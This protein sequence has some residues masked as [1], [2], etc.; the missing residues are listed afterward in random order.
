MNTVDYIDILQGSADHVDVDRDQLF[1]KDW[2]KFRTFHNKR[3]KRAWNRWFW[4]DISKTEQRFFRADWA[5]GTTYALADEVYYPATDAYYT[6]LRASTAEAPADSSGVTNLD[7]WAASESVLSASAFSATT[8]YVQGNQVTYSGTVYQMHTASGVANT[9]PTDTTYWGT[10]AA[11]NRYV[12]LDQSWQTNDIGDVRAC[13]EED[14]RA[15]T[16]NA[17]VP[18]FLSA[19]GIQVLGDVT[20]VWVQ[21]KDPVP[22]LAGDVFVDTTVYTAD[23]QVYYSAT[24][25]PGNFYKALSTTTAGDTPVSAAAKW[26]KIEI[27]LIF[28]DYL[29]LGGAAD[30][31]RS[32]T[33]LETAGYFS[34]AAQAE[35]DDRQSTETSAQ[36]QLPRTRVT[37]G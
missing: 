14:P 27:P 35:L 28:A 11:F 17:E 18:Y 2:F 20:N 33:Q 4:I 34:S 7:Y 31:E 22:K 23:Q 13:W 37:R 32:K 26:S 3:L 10:L 5:T 1:S 9:L 25:T 21:F 19:D 8:V 36:G 29:M 24:G 16:R 15:T 6:A 12:D 30:W